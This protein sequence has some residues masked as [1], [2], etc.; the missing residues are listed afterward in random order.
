VGRSPPP[1][2][3]MRG[4]KRALVAVPTLVT[5]VLLQSYFWVPSFEDQARGDAR[6]LTR[7]IDA[8]LGDASILNPVLSSDSVSSQV[9][10]L[11]FEG[12]ID[13]DF[14]LRFR[15]RLAESW[16]IF[17]EAYLVA[18]PTVA[19]GDG[20][21]ADGPTLRARVQAAAARGLLGPVEA[22]ALVPG[23]TETVSAP[24]AGPGGPGAGPSP[25]LTVR[26][27]D[28]VK[29][30]LQAVDQDLFEK[31]DRALGGYVGRLDATRH[32]DGPPDLV[33]THAAALVPVTEHNPVILF[34]LRRGV[35]FHDGHPFG[36]GD[37]TFTYQTLVDPQ[38]LSP[39][40]PSYEPVKSVEATGPHEVRVVYKRLFQPGFESW[41]MGILP[42]HLL[43]HDALGREARTRGRDPAGY[44]VR[45]ALFNRAPV[46]TGPFRFVDW[47]T[48]ELIR[49]GRFDGH[50]GGPPQ[51]SEY[52]LR[53]LP[54]RVTEELT[55]YAGTTDEYVAQP[56]QVH[57]LRQDPRFQT[58]SAL[59]LTYSYIGYNLRRPVF[60]D[61]RV[62]R[63]LGMAIDVQA[64]IDY[65][66]YGEAERTTG[67]L[68]KQTDFYDP[69]VA[70]LPYDPAGAARLLAEA[71]YRRNAAGWL[72]KDGQPL[73]FTLITNHGNEPRRAIM[74]IAQEAWRRLG[75]RVESLTI[76][77]AVFIKERINKLDFDAVVLGWTTPLDPDLFQVFHSSQTGEFQLNFVDYRNPRADELIVRLRQEYDPARQVT[78]AR[79]LHRV[80]AADQPYTFL[81]VPKTTTVLDRKLV[82]LVA[83][84]SGPPRYVPIVP[85]RV[86]GVRYHFTEWI[87]TP[88]PV[89][90][91][92][93]PR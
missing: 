41:S 2:E 39:R 68:P 5:A 93:T 65:V 89:A 82:R 13:R 76:E 66:L 81:Y 18:D 52:L 77:W 4:T 92:L 37:V 61:V 36:A 43:N 15:G 22:V 83:A 48:D 45:D 85:D 50:W 63:A 84:G 23:G 78:M 16:R 42:E 10:D 71:G 57:R 74:T 24:A 54:D 17:E 79:E 20:A 80:I 31:L 32:V 47:R 11:V 59:G 19:L 55:F 3:V 29:I 67:P 26:R 14:D 49:L 88:R 72:E 12:L 70:P 8:T 87:K 46:G 7:F 35:R 1:G 60:Q 30:T 64:I 28:R 62:R 91:D 9:N 75:I 86:G 44:T 51:L 6:R 27:P 25:V 53:I 38:N 56:H 40:V 34:T 58:F 69:A 73:A 33:R 21:R 90:L